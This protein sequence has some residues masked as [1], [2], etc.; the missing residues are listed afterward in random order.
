MKLVE[1]CLWCDIVILSTVK[2]L[3]SSCNP[4]YVRD[5]PD[6]AVLTAD[7]VLGNRCRPALVL[8]KIVKAVLTIVEVL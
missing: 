7:K 5:T 8:L 3:L 1:A 2:V 4:V 6:K